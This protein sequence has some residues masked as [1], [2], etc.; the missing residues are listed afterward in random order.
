MAVGTKGLNDALSLKAGPPRRH[1]FEDIQQGTQQG[2]F[3][4]PPDEN[5]PTVDF[6]ARVRARPGNQGSEGIWGD[7]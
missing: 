1:N 5:Q 4:P 3:M 2:L 7:H 6:P